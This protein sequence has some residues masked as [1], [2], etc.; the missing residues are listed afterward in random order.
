MNSLL[1]NPFKH[2]SNWLKGQTGP[3]TTTS[4]YSTRNRFTS[5]SNRIE[6][7]ANIQTGSVLMYKKKK[8]TRHNL[9]MQRQMHNSSVQ[10]ICDNEFFF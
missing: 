5:L 8:K 4:L 1:D 9:H 7:T 10:H 3:K 6:F 2:L